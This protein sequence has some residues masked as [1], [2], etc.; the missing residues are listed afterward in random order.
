[1]KTPEFLTVLDRLRQEYPSWQTPSVTLIAAT[2]RDPFRVLLSTVLSLRTKDEITLPASERLFALAPDAVALQAVPADVIEKAI[3]P[4]AFF[5][6]KARSLRAIA[7]E[8]LEKYDGEVPADLEVLLTLPGVGRKTA[9]LV[10]SLGH[11]LP[12]VCVDVHV[13]RICNRLDFV[14]SKTPEET[15]F[16]IR[17]KLPRNHWIE[18][19]DILVAFGQTICRP[20]SPFCSKCPVTEQ[21]PKRHVEKHR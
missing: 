4:V 14:R 12:A 1:M 13:H 9:N 11:N 17:R 6:N 21:C 7:A 15:E 5:R 18:L 2:K 20:V 8:L 19:N 16:A 10:M 3:Y